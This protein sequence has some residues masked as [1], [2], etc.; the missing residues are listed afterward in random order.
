[1]HPVYGPDVLLYIGETKKNETG[2]RTIERR[3]KEHLAG[4]FWSHTE[5]SFSIGV[6]EK[7][8][9]HEE[10]KAVESILIA[11][12]KPALNRASIDAANPGAREL[13]I[14]NYGFSRSLFPECSGSYWC[15]E[16][17]E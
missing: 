10:V 13:L 2:A 9:N 3:L 16:L 7:E 17:F 6:P 12:H 15:E 8:L 14:Q 5:L 1:M 11:A 4:R